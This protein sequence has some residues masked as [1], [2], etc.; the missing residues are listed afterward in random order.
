[1]LR[2]I[3]EWNFWYSMS[4]DICEQT[5]TP[6]FR[7]PVVR[8]LF[9]MHSLSQ[10]FISIHELNWQERLDFYTISSGVCDNF[11]LRSPESMI[12]LS[13][14]YWNNLNLNGKDC[15]GYRNWAH[16]CTAFLLKDLLLFSLSI[17]QGAKFFCYQK[18]GMDKKPAIMVA[19][20]SFQAC[21]NQHLEQ[22][23]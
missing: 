13:V 9:V 5:V 22:S 4:H 6:P 19:N 8:E 18:K 20:K 14:I 1:M 2:A 7:V 10:H 21:F 12:W 17:Y 11:Y 3:C 16:Y 23:L 15:L